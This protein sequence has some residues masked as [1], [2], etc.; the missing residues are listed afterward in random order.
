[1]ARLEA[2]F[3][4]DIS[5]LEG[6][7]FTIVAPGKYPAVITG[8]DLDLTKDKSGL[9]LTIKIQIIDGEFKGVEIND[10]LNIKN[11][12]TIA[13]KIGIERKARLGVILCGTPNPMDTD[14]FLN[15]P[16]VVE[17]FTEPY[18]IVDQYTGEKKTRISNKIKQYHPISGDYKD[19]I[20]GNPYAKPASAPNEQQR[21]MEMATKNAFNVPHTAKP[22]DDE[23][24]F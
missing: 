9:K 12:N 18:E 1:M 2:D 15:K 16:L 20:K 19:I 13:Q 5:E 24:P 17:T 14:M 8:A 6:G 7:K 21:Y 22:I 23:I 3:M 11:H 10:L 4:G